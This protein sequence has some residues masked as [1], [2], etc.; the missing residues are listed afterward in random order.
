MRIAPVLAMLP[1]LAL[2][3]LGCGGDDAPPLTDA[4]ELACPEPGAL[5]FRLASSGFHDEANR[6]LAR[7]YPRNKDEAGDLLGNP[8]GPVATS[9]FTAEMASATAAAFRGAKARTATTNGLYS[10]PLP[11][12]AVS[13][14][15][16][17]AAAAAW[18]ALGDARTDAD[19]IYELPGDAAP[20]AP[21]YAM[22]EADGSCAEHVDYRLPRGSK[23]VLSDIDGTLTT[24][25]E[26]LYLQL[27]DPAYVP[28]MKT[29]ADRLAQ[30]WAA[31]GYPIVYLTA[32]THVFRV[33][34]RGWLRDLGF[35][36]GPVITSTDL[37][38]PRPYKAGWVKRLTEDFGWTIV[39]A[40]GNADTDIQAYE[41][42]GIPKAL[43]FI[44]GEHAGASGTVAIPNDDYTQHIAS[45]VEAQPDNR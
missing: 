21:I 44:I 13:L 11:G 28:A 3:T 5:P 35:P 23:I 14:W 16:Y 31:K 8:G 45:F 36:S 2:G 4:T 22:L 6:A 30:T 18:S 24:R 39:A 43:T 40:Y 25:D 17:D 41:D 26:E 20:G 9:Y 38:N 7:S 27:G 34:T 33:E 37:G 29:A 15:Q 19:G 12:E 1:S 42:A 32:R 10:T